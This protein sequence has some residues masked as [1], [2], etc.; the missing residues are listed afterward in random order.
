LL[1]LTTIK[2]LV[3]EGQ[4]IFA[5]LSTPMPDSSG[6]LPKGIFGCDPTFGQGLDIQ[7]EPNNLFDIIK[8]TG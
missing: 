5:I 6:N 3:E 1:P 4:K 7:G 8:P 2:L